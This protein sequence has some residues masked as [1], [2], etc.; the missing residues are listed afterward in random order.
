MIKNFKV[1]IF[2]RSDLKDLKVLH[3]LKKKNKFLKIIYDKKSTKNIF[4]NK[5]DILIS[6]RSKKIFK[7]KELSKA[8]IAAINFHPGPPEFRGIGCANFAIMKN[9]SFYGYT[10][11]VMSE[12]I[13]SGK[14]LFCYKF[15]INNKINITQLLKFTHN[16][17]DT[18]LIEVIKMISQNQ[19][20]NKFLNVNKKIKWSKKIYKKKDLENLYKIKPAFISKKKLQNILRAT[21]YKNFKPFVEINGSKF[22][23]HE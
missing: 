20:V 1:I 4:N 10:I 23:Y 12:K 22:F 6:Y 18:K 13:D 2:T 3:D 9:S 8:R 11:H 21:L 14:I 17:M 15:K 19:F 7:K 16:K 5:C